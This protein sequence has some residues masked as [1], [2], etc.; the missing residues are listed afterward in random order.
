MSLISCDATIVDKLRNVQVCPRSRMALAKVAQQPT[1]MPRVYLIMKHFPWQKHPTKSLDGE[2]T[3]L[4]DVQNR[5]MA[6]N[7]VKS[8]AKDPTQPPREGLAFRGC[9]E[10]LKLIQMVLTEFLHVHVLLI[11]A[12]RVFTCSFLICTFQDYGQGS[13]KR[14]AE[15]STGMILKTSPSIDL[16]HCLPRSFTWVHDPNRRRSFLHL[17]MSF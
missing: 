15:I 16:K 13:S 12:M 14:H 10:S 2:C 8:R 5:K 1:K 9:S 3:Y 4:F 17:C 7:A 11:I 6:W